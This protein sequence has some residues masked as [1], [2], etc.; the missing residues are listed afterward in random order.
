MLHISV[1]EPKYETTA[2]QLYP[3]IRNALQQRGSYHQFILETLLSVLG[4]INDIIPHISAPMSKLGFICQLYLTWKSWKIQQ[5]Y[6]KFTYPFQVKFMPFLH[7]LKLCNTISFLCLWI[8]KYIIMSINDNS[9]F[10]FHH[11][12]LLN[13]LWENSAFRKKRGK[14]IECQTPFWLNMVNYQTIRTVLFEH[15]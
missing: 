2:L 5:T 9:H 8:K 14:T 15:Y 4:A 7:S 11:F 13:I 10:A 1:F 6:P 12:G 3:G